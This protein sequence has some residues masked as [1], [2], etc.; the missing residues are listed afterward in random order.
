MIIKSDPW[1][2]IDQDD[3]FDEPESVF[4]YQGAI[5]VPK[6]GDERYRP[7]LFSPDKIKDVEL[8]LD[9]KKGFQGKKVNYAT[10]VIQFEHC[11]VTASLNSGKSKI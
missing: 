5:G 6:E 11:I 8:L 3:S 9:I 1:K 2:N 7:R 4:M 10:L